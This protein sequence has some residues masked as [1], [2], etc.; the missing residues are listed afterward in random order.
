[1]RGLVI[2]VLGSIAAGILLALVV[3]AHEL[4]QRLTLLR[5]AFIRK[6]PTKSLLLRHLALVSRL[7]RFWLSR[8]RLAQLAGSFRIRPGPHYQPDAESPACD[9]RQL[10]G[11]ISRQGKRVYFL[12]ADSG[13]GKTAVGLA[14]PLLREPKRRRWHRL[15]PIYID[16]S[17]ADSEEPI[18]EI[19]SLLDRLVNGQSSNLFG[20]PLFVIDALNE[21]VNPV[22]VCERLARRSRELETVKATLLFLFSVRHRSHPAQLRRSLQAEGLGPVEQMEL[23]FD[24]TNDSDLSFFPHL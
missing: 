21:A 16:L 13:F 19:E 6:Q 9:A 24:P 10:L 11:H 23:L 20:R 18:A 17:D 22:R 2:G 15:I 3:K 7:P 1:M 14:L 5:L 8:S 4:W 12:N